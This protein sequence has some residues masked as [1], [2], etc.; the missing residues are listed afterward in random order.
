MVELAEAAVNPLMF[1]T[2]AVLA[3]VVMLVL[4]EEYTP[5]EVD[6][7]VTALYAA[8]VTVVSAPTRNW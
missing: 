2:D 5:I 6:T 4:A 3:G 7:A 1:G 8:L